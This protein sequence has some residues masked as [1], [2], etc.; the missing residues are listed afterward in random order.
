M[1]PNTLT[2]A[3]AA[4]HTRDLHGA[5]TRSRLAALAQCCKPSYWRA[6]LRNAAMRIAAVRTRRDTVACV[7]C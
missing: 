5:A 3:V 1:N 4:E 7:S 6:A 2:A